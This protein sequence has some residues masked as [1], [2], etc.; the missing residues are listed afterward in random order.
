MM[1]VPYKIVV[2]DQEFN[3]YAS[4]IDRSK[5]VV[6]DK[7]YQRDY[8]TFWRFPDGVSKGSGPARNFVWDHSISSGA[9]WHWIMDDN[10]NGF[11]RL[12]D[13]R[14]IKVKD[15]TIFRIMEDFVLRYKNVSM[16]G[17]NYRFFVNNYSNPPIIINSR[18]YSCI[19]I[20]NSAPFRWRGRYNE[21]VDL[22]I[23]MLKAGF[24]T[25]QFNAFLQNKMATQSMK[26]GNTAAFYAAEGTLPKSKMLV[27]MHPDVTKLVKRYGRWHHHVDYSYFK[28]HNKLIRDPSVIVQP[29]TNNYGLELRQTSPLSN[30]INGK[31]KA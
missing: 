19:L 6:L 7:A 18:I 23:R 11:V 2:E 29:G 21:D 16:A 3:D 5:I 20:R 4:V 25:I 8:D 17:P 26:G 30:R 12:N 28:D 13:N 31:S 9:E 14:K 22:S 27:E 10:I 1:N 24:C 15:G